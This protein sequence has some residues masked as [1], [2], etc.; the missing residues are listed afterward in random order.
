MDK[1]RVLVVEDEAFTGLEIE[2]TVVD[3]EFAVVGPMPTLDRALAAAAAAAIDAA[4]LDANIG[5]ENAGSVAAVLTRRRVPFLVLSGYAREFLPLSFAHAP[6]IQK[7]FDRARLLAVLRH[8][9]LS[10][11]GDAPVKGSV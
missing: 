9:C 10:G 7:P 2:A 3:A 4:V 5:G 6:L 1:R 11:C 8:L